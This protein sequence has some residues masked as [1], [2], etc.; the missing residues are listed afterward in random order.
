[1]HPNEAY[2]MKTCEEP[3]TTVATT[4]TATTTTTTSAINTG[5][6]NTTSGE[7]SNAKETTVSAGE[8]IG[9]NQQDL[10]IDGLI[11]R[12]RT[13]VVCVLNYTYKFLN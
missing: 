13:R 6:L 7:K 12:R 10:S 2:W 11:P 5:D 8:G 9:N 3:T 1:M 4:V